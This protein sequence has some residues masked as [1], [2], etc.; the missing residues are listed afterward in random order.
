M[1]TGIKDIAISWVL[2]AIR[3]TVGLSN[4]RN[5][6]LKTKIN[7][8]GKYPKDSIYYGETFTSGNTLND[9]YQLINDFEGSVKTKLIFTANGEVRRNS[10]KRMRS[11][12][13]LVESH[14]V[15]F[16]LDKEHNSV[17]IIDPSRK[18]GKIGIYNPYIGICLEP[19]FRSRGYKVKWLEM[20]SPCQI[21]YH[22]VFCQSWT[23]YL[24]YKYLAEKKDIIHIPS[25]QRKKYRKLLMFFKEL[26]DFESFKKELMI[27]YNDNIV[28]HEDFVLLKN[29]D[30]CNVLSLMRTDDMNDDM[31]DDTNDDFECECDTG[32]T[33]IKR[34]KSVIDLTSQ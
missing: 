14:Y 11:R 34:S 31:N 18:N 20:S 19:F 24:T 22:D 23:M 17:V 3:E 32:V 13:E 4:V 6:I 21:N 2:Y 30:P 16:I 10:K 26:I 9:I 1:S 28:D 12:S 25:K 29:Y 5:E 8:L 33:G 27:S 7:K 15:S